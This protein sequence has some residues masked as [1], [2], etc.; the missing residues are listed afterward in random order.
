MLKDLKGK[1]AL[2]TGASSGLGVDFARILAGRGCHLVLVARREEQ[3][4]A[5]AN[6]LRT[7]HAVEVD[8]VPMDLNPVV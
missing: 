7:A 2:V 5:V 4:L 8:V 6:E 3:L 1:R